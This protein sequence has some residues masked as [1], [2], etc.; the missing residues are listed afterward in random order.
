MKFKSHFCFLAV[1]LLTLLTANPATANDSFGSFGGSWGSGLF[2]SSGGPVR[3]FLA[4][5]PVR[6]LFGRVQGRLSGLASGGS[7]GSFGSSGGWGST[8]A[9]WGSRGSSFGSRGASFGSRGSSWGSRGSGW[10]SRGG[11]GSTGYSISSGGSWGSSTG[12]STGHSSGGSWGSTSYSSA[13]SMPAYSAPVVSTPYSNSMSGQI[14]TSPMSET[15]FMGDM[16]STII[17]PGGTMGTVIQDG[18]FYAPGS[19]VDPNMGINEAAPVAPAPSNDGGGL[20]PP[21]NPDPGPSDDVTTLMRRTLL[22]SQIDVRLPADAQIYVNGNLTTSQGAE[23]NFVSRN[24]TAGK[25]YRYEIKAVLDGVEKVE[26]F[27]MIAG[28]TKTLDFDFT[29]TTVVALEVPA[30]AN[31]ELAGNQIKQNG[32]TLREFKTTSL[33]DGETWDDYKIVVSVVREGERIS[34]EKTIKVIGGESY[35]LAFDFD[36]VDAN[37]VAAK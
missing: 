11:W 36:Q 31:I 3:N 9:S 10:S 27:T 4:N 34:Q 28:G 32:K 7:G 2:G 21:G 18:S 19:V 5:A 35:A 15:S 14:I 17:A 29:A 23:R 8:G 20:T 37:S 6:N 26:E 16:G 30:D 24:Q 33:Q 25:I 1:A 13:V 22:E 12:G